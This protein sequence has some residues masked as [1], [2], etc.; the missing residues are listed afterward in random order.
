MRHKTLISFCALVLVVLCLSG[1]GS[2]SQTASLEVTCDEFKEQPAIYREMEI[3]EGSTLT[4]TLCT[5]ATS[6]FLWA[7]DAEIG[8]K[9]VLTQV[10]HVV[11]GKG[12]LDAS[13]EEV[14]TFQALNTGNTTVFLEYN[15]PWEIEDDQKLWTLDLFVVVK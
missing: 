2:S 3:T 4:V 8:R 1:C 5:S 15:R 6:G 12:I 10:D 13:T 14:W 7:E 9:M 11:E